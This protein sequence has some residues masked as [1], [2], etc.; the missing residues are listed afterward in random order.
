MKKLGSRAASRGAFIVLVLLVAYLAL[1]G[2]ALA[3]TLTSN[4]LASLAVLVIVSAIAIPFIDMAF[5]DKLP[6][7]SSWP[8]PS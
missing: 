1:G 3:T 2:I 8:T 6:F 5:G 7:L 4:W